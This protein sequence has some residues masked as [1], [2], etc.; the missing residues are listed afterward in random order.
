MYH[1]CVVC[2][3]LTLILFSSV[4]FVPC[5]YSRYDLISSASVVYVYV[6]LCGGVNL[7][8]ATNFSSGFDDTGAYT[9]DHFFV[10]L[11]FHAR[12]CVGFVLCPCPRLLWAALFWT[13]RCFG[14]G[15]S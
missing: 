13:C 8:T 10:V 5:L 2:L 7:P 12:L 4:I 3:V 9:P 14:S 11:R 15:V 6:S 1:G